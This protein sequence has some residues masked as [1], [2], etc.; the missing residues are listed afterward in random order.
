MLKLLS[1]FKV[2][3]GYTAFHDDES[4]YKFYVL[5]AA[6]RFR[7]NAENGRPVFQFLKYK[8]P[9]PRPPK[10]PGDL[11][12]SGGGFVIFDVELAIDESKMPKIMEALQ[13]RVPQAPGG[14]KPPIVIAPLTPLSGSVSLVLLD[15]PA[16]G[17]EGGRFVEKVHAAAA[18]TLYGSFVTPFT[19]ELSQEG[20]TLLE[21]ALQ[22][23]GAT[24][25]VSYNLMVPVRLPDA[26]VNV[27]FS[28]SKFASFQQSIEVDWDACGD[29][30][31]RENIRETFQQSDAGGVH[32]EIG[33]GVALPEKEMNDLRKELRSWG[34]ATL[35]DAVKRMILG[36]IPPVP[37][38]KRK[39]PDGIE[40]AYRNFTVSKSASFS[41][42]YREGM[43]F[44]KDLGPKAGLPNI[45]EMKDKNG[46]AFKW[47]D[48]AKTVDLD[49]PFFRS[50]AVRVAVGADFKNLPIDTIEVK[51]KYKTDNDTKIAEFIFDEAKVRAEG[52]AISKDPSGDMAFTPMLSNNSRDYEFEYEVSYKGSSKTLK[53]PAQKVNDPILKINVD[54]TG[55]F[56]VDVAAGDIDFD[57]VKSA[58]V[59]VAYDDVEAGVSPVAQTV[60]L[61]KEAKEA[62]IQ[63]LIFKPRTTPYKYR[64][65]YKINSGRE[66]EVDWKPEQSRRLFVN[67]PFS[68][69]KTINV[70]S[71]GD[72]EARIA[73]IQ[74][75][76]EYAD[77]AAAYRQTQSVNLSKATPFFDWNVPVIDETRGAVSYSA[78]V[79]L[80]NGTVLEIPKTEAKTPTIL[81]GTPVIRVSVMP[82]L[83]DWDKLKLV[84]V[85]MRY[86]DQANAIDESD[87]LVF[88]KSETAGKEWI[89]DIADRAKKEYEWEATYFLADGTQKKG[90]VTKS[91]DET[92]LLE[93]PT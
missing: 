71:V 88:K 60:T 27:W 93:M 17:Q 1:Q 15:A 30:E 90:A 75:D 18:P 67:D 32:V 62:K 78:K 79:F 48:F 86:K 46:N 72:L 61:T 54:D 25:Q 28:A 82:D 65:K 10:K 73:N 49:D 24:A 45:T 57:E 26:T 59:S 43:V 41:R 35:E 91:T 12:S 81:V 92:L 55:I 8:N 51:L 33:G 21:K 52:S 47:A 77:D 13:A 56:A 83:L 63:A 66:Y 84:K 22:G 58:S 31:Y 4:P 29:D 9:M 64:V 6:A 68:A 37:E 2:I 20:A 19:A 34:F 5:P 14:A 39:L 80:K 70:R 76:L 42:S 87:D 44:Q 23:G 3:E 38:D 40:K 89:L 53:V 36:D 69:Q 16:P 7:I 74:V 85:T 11:P 50:L